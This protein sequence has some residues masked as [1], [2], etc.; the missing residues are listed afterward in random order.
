[1]LTDGSVH[2]VGVTKKDNEM[3]LDDGWEDL[4]R[5][6]CLHLV[7]ERLEFTRMPY[8]REARCG[9]PPYRLTWYPKFN[10]RTNKKRVPVCH[11]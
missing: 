11:L 5:E 1:M 4:V 3:G 2:K 8:N 7:R 9:T 6:C 10:Q